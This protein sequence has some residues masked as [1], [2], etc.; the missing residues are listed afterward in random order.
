[1]QASVFGDA[2]LISA[3]LFETLEPWLEVLNLALLADVDKELS[4]DWRPLFFVAML[5]AVCAR[6]TSRV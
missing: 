5:E 6:R 4:C 1:M 3:S 2:E